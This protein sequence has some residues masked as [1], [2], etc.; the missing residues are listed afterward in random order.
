V[1]VV[2]P[3][4]P[5]TRVTGSAKSGRVRGVS[6]L[7]GDWTAMF[8]GRAGSATLAAGSVV[9]LTRMFAPSQ[10]GAIAYFTVVSLLIF[11]IASAWTSLATVRYGRDAL[12]SGGLMTA[13]SWGRLAVTFPPYVT[14]VVLVVGI[15][16]L[17]AFPTEFSWTLAWLS[18]LYGTA[19]IVGDHCLY[20]LEAAGRMKLSALS[21]F[22]RQAVLVVLL[23]IAFLVADNVSTS[24]AATVFVLSALL[25]ALA[26]APALW[27]VA[28]WPVAWDRLTIRRLLVFS[29]PVIAF[30]VSQ[31]VMRFVDVVMIRAFGDA[32]DA[33]LYALAYQ[34]YGV[35][36]QLASAAMIVLTPVFVSMRAGGKEHLIRAFLERLAPALTLAGATA[37]GL[38]APIVVTLVPTL[39]G[40]RFGPTAQPFAILMLPLAMFFCAS[41]MMPVLVLHERARELGVINGVAALVNVVGDAVLIGPLHAGISGPAIATA[42]SLGVILIGYAR[43]G[44]RCTGARLGIRPIW[45]APCVAGVVPSVLFDGSLAVLGGLLSTAAASLL[46]LVAHSPVRSGDAEFIEMM[47]IPPVVKRIALRSLAFASR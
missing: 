34:G 7:V 6:T 35:L 45:L 8:V 9:L 27:K 23:A 39:F 4:R 14:T 37:A 18:I 26:V 19:L 33:G 41:L 46:I 1:T 47:R 30:T 5:Q 44:Q 17:G 24:E 28:L 20:L 3:G 29:L 13:V 31:Y 21:Q 11:T 25:P 36:Q 42:I 12:E 38:A 16:A 43:V 40:D 15:E 2:H 32:A 22:M 10:Y